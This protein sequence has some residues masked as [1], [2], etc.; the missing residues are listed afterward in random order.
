MSVTFL[1]EIESWL[2]KNRWTYRKRREA[3]IIEMDMSLQCELNHCQV[4]VWMKDD[5]C[6][7]MGRVPLQVEKDARTRVGEYLCR[8]NYGLFSGHFDL[9]Y[10]DGEIRYKAFLKKDETDQE[11]RRKNMEEA[12]VC[13]AVMFDMYGPGLLEVWRGERT[14]AEVM[15]NINDMEKQRG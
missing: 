2:K 8:V 4:I 10:D 14:P 15:E 13:P 1:N 7:V 12:L 9:N 6:F 11:Q 5:D 3:G